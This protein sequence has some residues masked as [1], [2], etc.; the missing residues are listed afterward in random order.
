MAR[1]TPNITGQTEVHKAV[2]STS[3]AGHPNGIFSESVL[4]K[5]I[6]QLQLAAEHA[7]RKT[8]EIAHRQFDS[9]R[10]APTPAPTAQF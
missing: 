10:D 3:P 7:E 6:F 8:N 1:Y 2:V 9:L 5:A 4:T